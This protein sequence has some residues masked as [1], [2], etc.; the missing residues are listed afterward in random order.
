MEISIN[1]RWTLS[2]DGKVLTIANAMSTPQG[3]FETK[4]VADKH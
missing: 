4:I 1:E 3:D 2:P